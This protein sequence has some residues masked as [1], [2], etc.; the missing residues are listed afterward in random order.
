MTYKFQA[1]QY[2]STWYH[3]HFTLQYG[4]GLL[5][6]L[7]INGPASANYDV[8]LGAMFLSDWSH[9][10]IFSRWD[11]A[12]QG[13][14]PALDNGLI[15]GTNIYNNSGTITGSRWETT[16][17]AGTTYRLRLINSAVDGYIRFSIDDHDFQ[18]I[19]TDLVPIV[20]YTTDNII[21]G[22]GQR[23]DVV[24]TA[25]QTS[26]DYWLRATWQTTCSR[27][28]AAG[29]ILGIVRYDNSSTADP[30]TTIGDFEDTC[31]D[32]P[33]A[34]LSPYLNLQVGDSAEETEL[35]LGSDDIGYF[36]WTINS[37]AINSSSLYLNWENPTFLKIFNGDSIFPANYSVQPVTVVDKWVYWV[38]VDKSNTGATHPIHLHGHDFFVLAQDTGLWS[39]DVALNTDNP[40]RRDVA[41]LPANGYLVL[42]WQSDNPGSWLMH[43]H[44]A[45]HASE[46]LAMQFVERESE[47]NATIS[48]P[49]LLVDTCKS[50]NSY[51]PTEPFPQDDSGI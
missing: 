30:T 40:P 34:S 42:A 17:E 12:R 35:D 11:S 39:T 50:W 48:D 29:N 4:E 46:G 31:G 2:G 45:W 16:V 23:Y 21:I 14:P 3:S 5:G 7:I 51:Y 36:H 37:T 27:N 9:T 6:P 47:I 15:N 43:C 13:L 32:E 26:G 33:L 18:V 41:S 44:I 20:P 10:P 1:T 49:S 8:D 28:L 25:N 24:F 38:I 22:I 19:A